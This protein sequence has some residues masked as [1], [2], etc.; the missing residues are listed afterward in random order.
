MNT[1]SI[2]PLPRWR[3]FNLL[4]KFS[5]DNSSKSV[6]FEQRNPRFQESDFQWISDWGFNFVRLP[7][8][9]HCW[10]SPEHWFEKDEAVLEQIDEAIKFGQKYHV[11]VCLNLH[12]APGYCVNPPPEPLS[13]WKDATALDACSHHW[14]N[15][16]KRYRGIPST[17]L[18]FDLLNEPLNTGELMSRAEHEYVIRRLVNDI[19]EIDPERLIIADGLNYGN[20]P[21]PELVDLGIHQSCR[22]YIPMGISHY[23]A[24]WVRGETFPE[25]EWPGGDHF[26]E[27]WDRHHLENHYKRWADLMAEGVGVHCG[28]GGC[29]NYTPHEVFL[30]WFRD[31]L[32]ILTQFGIGYSLWNFR[33]AFGV[34]DSGRKDVA[35]QDWYGHQLDKPL[36]DLL[37]RF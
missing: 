23:Q 17:Q 1:N 9:Y 33:G 4:E 5:A 22:A 10:S 3:G 15:F 8:S 12:R 29:Y 21:I 36:L 19:R 6:T 20:D 24:S 34:L 32:D 18:S 11:H 37:K 16:G 31:V 13:L 7:M 25:P 28:E 2:N 14:T 30:N 27:K 26:G 35:Y